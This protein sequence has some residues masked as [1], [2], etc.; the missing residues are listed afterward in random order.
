MNHYYLREIDHCILPK[1]TRSTYWEMFQALYR[2]VRQM[3]Y[4]LNRV[5]EEFYFAEIIK[6]K[7]Q[8]DHRAKDYYFESF[9]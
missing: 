3:N 1:E 4:D 7:D 5:R 6:N 8:F 9:H 2:I